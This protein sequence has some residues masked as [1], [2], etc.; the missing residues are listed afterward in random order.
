MK[1]VLLVV[2]HDK[3]T[4]DK[5]YLYPDTEDGFHEAKSKCLSNYEY[6][7]EES[8]VFNIGIFAC[9]YSED[10]FS[11]INRVEWAEQEME[12]VSVPKAPKHKETT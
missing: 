4:E 11:T 8:I 9:G 1:T 12:T 5:Y 7:D 10:Y 2:V 3:Y 6:D